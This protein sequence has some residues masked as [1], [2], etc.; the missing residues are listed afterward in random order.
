MNTCKI[1]YEV[2]KKKK[3]ITLGIQKFFEEDT[4]SGASHFFQLKK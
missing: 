1:Y 4:Q 3:S 2:N